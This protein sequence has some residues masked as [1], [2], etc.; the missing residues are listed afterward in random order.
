MYR[1][2]LEA[3]TADQSDRY[4]AFRRVKLNPP[5]VRRVRLPLTAL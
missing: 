5:T 4:D 1:I 3:F 2:L